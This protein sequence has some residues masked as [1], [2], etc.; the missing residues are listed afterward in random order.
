MPDHTSSG[1]LIPRCCSG[2]RLDAFDMIAELI[3]ADAGAELDAMIELGF[4]LVDAREA[5]EETYGAWVFARI[6]N[7]IQ[8]VVEVDELLREAA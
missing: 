8:F 3:A 1:D 7:A 4:P 5:V 2:H 6:R